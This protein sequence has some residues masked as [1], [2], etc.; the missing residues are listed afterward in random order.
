MTKVKICGLR[1]K[2]DVLIANKY[3]PNYIGF[4]FAE[5]SPRKITKDEAIA[6]KNLL[7]NDIIAVGVFRNNPIDDVI[8]IASSGAINMIQLHG[9]E[10]EEYINRLKKEVKLPI[11]KAYSNYS[12]ADYALFDSDT[13]GEGKVFD[14][15]KIDHTKPFFLAGGI[16]RDNILEAL[17]Q[18]PYCID[19]SSSLETNGFKDEAKIK[20]FIRL[21]RQNER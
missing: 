5:K 15:S 6:L 3:R 12:N 8:D 17:K 13:P 2:E 20:E 7:N 18:N 19:A 21:V 4:V 9:S 14:W 16:S 1:R 11:I 10:D